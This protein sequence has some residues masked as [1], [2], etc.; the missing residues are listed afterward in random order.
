M[1]RFS[2]THEIDSVI[3]TMGLFDSPGYPN[4]LLPQ[5]SVGDC[6]SVRSSGLGLG[7]SLWLCLMWGAGGRAA[8]FAVI[9]PY[10]L[11]AAGSEAFLAPAS[12]ALLLATLLLSLV[13][14]VALI[15]ERNG[16]R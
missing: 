14:A 3:G 6:D 9:I 8:F 4:L 2:S 12:L 11:S 7:S 15:R 5:P 10:L 13:Q 1:Q 16:A